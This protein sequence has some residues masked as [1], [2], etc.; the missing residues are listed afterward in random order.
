[1]FYKASDTMA[2]T[3]AS[4]ATV[5]QSG[6]ADIMPAFNAWRDMLS[7]FTGLG[8]SEQQKQSA[9]VSKELQQQTKECTRCEQWRDQVIEESRQT[10]ATTRK[11][12]Q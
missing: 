9:S 3:T 6:D 12:A 2:S 10:F 8:L 1:M 4:S 5:H 7:A 11:K